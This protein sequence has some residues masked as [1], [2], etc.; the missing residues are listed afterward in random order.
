MLELLRYCNT[1]AALT[2]IILFG[3][4]VEN[5]H[6][7]ISKQHNF[8]K[9]KKKKENFQIFRN[10]LFFNIKISNL[11]NYLINM[12]SNMASFKPSSEKKKKKEQ[13]A[14]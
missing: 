13:I 6:Q 8:V 2:L 10:I 14:L 4:D 5:F 1:L 9:K 7:K 12:L 11:I 3:K